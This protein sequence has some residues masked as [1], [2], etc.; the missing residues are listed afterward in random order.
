LLNDPLNDIKINKVRLKKKQRG[1]R[2]EKGNTKITSKK[3]SW[4]KA[5]NMDPR[6]DLRE[7]GAGCVVVMERAK[8]AGSWGHEVNSMIRRTLNG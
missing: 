1:N 5:V 6:L 8:E 3:Q 7:G 4:L 2:K